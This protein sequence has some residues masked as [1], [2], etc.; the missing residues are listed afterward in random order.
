MKQKILLV[1]AVVFGLIAFYLTYTQLQYEKNKLRAR[2]HRVEVIRLKTDKTEGETIEESDITNFSVER[3]RSQR[4][5]EILWKNRFEIIKQKADRSMLAGTILRYSDIKNDTSRKAGL[6]GIIAMGM[7]AISISVDATSSVSSMIKPEDRVDILGT[8]RFPEMK[9]DKSLDVVTL[10]ILQSVRILATG[11]H[12]ANKIAGS[13]KGGRTS[14]YST[15]T[16]EL[17]PKEVEMIVFATQKGRLVL[18]LRSYN[19]TGFE[20][21][22]QSVNFK[23]LQDHIEEYNKERERLQGLQ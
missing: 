14:G 3:F 18:S 1:A 22:F 19:E 2:T 6:A 4:S 21:K 5:D 16:L 7:R 13:R 9:G 12:L 20:D 17:T 23:Y 15:V 8:F 11:K 10:T